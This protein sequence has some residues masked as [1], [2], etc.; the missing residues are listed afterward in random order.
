MSSDFEFSPFANQN[1][2]VSGMKVYHRGSLVPH[3]PCFV[4]TKLLTTSFVYVRKKNASRLLFVF[5][6]PTPTV[7]CNLPKN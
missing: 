5:H 3:K 7:F 1:L 6:V 4:P 2:A